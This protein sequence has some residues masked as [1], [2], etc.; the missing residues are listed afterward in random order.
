MGKWRLLKI[1][2]I[3]TGSL[4]VCS[5]IVLSLFV[6][7]VGKP[8]AEIAETFG[9]CEPANPTQLEELGKF[10]L[11]ASTRNLESKCF[12]LQGWGVLAS[13]EMDAT[14]LELFITSSLIETPLS[15]TEL[16]TELGFPDDMESHLYGK[17]EAEF[18]SQYILI[19]TSDP[20]VFVVYVQVFGS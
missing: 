6:L 17:Y 16:P 15:T 18:L 5:A 2:M 10:R 8:L 7:L 9:G 11:P 12:G 13:F 1:I 3:A 14:D 19:D 20:K 4:F